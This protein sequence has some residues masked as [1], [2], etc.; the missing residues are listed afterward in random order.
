MTALR[1]V[2]ITTCVTSLICSLPLVYLYGD[3]REIRREFRSFTEKVH[4]RDL[5]SL[6]AEEDVTIKLPRTLRDRVDALEVSFATVPSRLEKLESSDGLSKKEKME[7]KK[8]V[9]KQMKK[10][11]S[12][13]PTDSRSLSPNR[14][15]S[16]VPSKI[17][18][19]MPTKPSGPPASD[20]PSELPS[21]GPPTCFID[22]A[23]LKQAVDLFL[24]NRMS[25]IALHGEIGSWCTSSVQS[26][27]GLFSFAQLFNENIGSWDLSAITSL[28]STFQNARIFNGDISDWDVSVNTSLEN[29]FILASMFNG[30]LSGWDLTS[31]TSLVRTFKG[32]YGEGL[33]SIF[34]GDITGWDVSSNTNLAFTFEYAVDFNRDIS[35]WDNSLVRNLFYTF[36]YASSF[37]INISGWDILSV[38][39]MKGIFYGAR[40]FNQC[41]DWS[42][43]KGIPTT[44]MFSGSDGSLGP[45]NGE[46]PPSA[47]PSETSSID[48]VFDND[49]LMKALELFSSNKKKAEKLYGKIENWS[50]SNV[51][52][53]SVFQDDPCYEQ[54]DENDDENDDIN[55]RDNGHHS[56]T[57]IDDNYGC[58]DAYRWPTLFYGNPFFNEAI[59]YWDV[60]SVTKF[61]SAFL[62]QEKFNQ[63]ISKWDV[64]SSTSFY[65][66]F[67]A[68]YKFNQDLSS[69]DISL[70]TIFK[71]MFGDASAFN[72]CL[73]WSNSI[74]KGANLQDMFY[75]TKGGKFC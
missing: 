2:I 27:Q 52:D 35:E 31:V 64:S 56:V 11:S 16:L 48:V 53:L 75:K 51:M 36:T 20:V 45:C 28:H 46:T 57:S 8:H 3:N 6:T 43:K 18:S 49:G 22:K 73:D 54:D 59:G 17:S 60:S 41:L 23:A 30:D 63:D 67:R 65:D 72:Q 70:G 69:W 9:R 62:D 7:V 66:T 10:F 40:S 33:A 15:P 21:S 19:D 12:S 32:L 38:T 29:T 47:F 25:A 34:N 42:I 5:K 55:N 74:K 26:F 61:Y 39:T 44:N 68:A 37:N 58:D 71:S 24:K 13:S 4:R 1:I 14:K 50:T